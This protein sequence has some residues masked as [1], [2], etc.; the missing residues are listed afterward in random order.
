[1]LSFKKY[2]VSIVLSIVLLLGSFFAPAL[3]ISAKTVEKIGVGEVYHT[4]F[5]GGSE[6]GCFVFAPETNGFYTLNIIDYSQTS[7]VYIEIVDITTEQ[8]YKYIFE[9]V[10]ES[11]FV[12]EKMYMS[13]SHEYEVLCY[14]S[15]DDYYSDITAD[16]ALSFELSDFEPYK[17]PFC[18]ISSSRVMVSFE[19]SG[20]WFKFTTDV[21]GD[22]N[23]NY[24]VAIDAYVEV[25]N[26][27]SGEMV[28][29]RYTPFL[30]NYMGYNMWLCSE[31]LVFSLEANTEYYFYIEEYRNSTSKV[32]VTKS[33]KDIEN[34]A[35]SSLI[36]NVD[37]SSVDASD[38]S[39]GAFYFNIFYT[40]KTSQK[41]DYYNATSLGIEMPYVEYIGKTVYVNGLYLPISNTQPISVYYDGKYTVEYVNIPSVSD[42]LIELGYRSH[43]YF[44]TMEILYQNEDVYSE[45]KRIKVDKT[46]LYE[47][48][49]NADLNEAFSEYNIVLIDEQNNIVSSAGEYCWPL[50]AGREYVLCL[51][52]CYNEGFYNNL[53]FFISEKFENMY[54]DAYQN[55]WYYDAVTY[56]TGVNIMTGYQ[57]GRFGV[58]DNIQR[59]DF[60]VMLARFDGVDL[61]EYIDKQSPF[62][63][64]SNDPDCYF[65]AAVIWGYE[66]GIVSGYQDGNFG[67]G[68]KI[69]R[70]QLVTFLYRYANYKG[71]DT[72]YTTTEK[73]N[74]ENQ[75]SDFEFVTDFA[76]NSTIWAVTNGVI[77]GKTS[78]T[79]VPHGNALRCEV[80]QIMYNVFRNKVF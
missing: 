48:F 32:S 31:K 61:S 18:D 41:I 80:A 69:T 35:I 66:N 56:T 33:E 19:E 2:V 9:D 36:E 79:I 6:T 42:I 63:D 20:E 74:V 26:A 34:I 16:I 60:L 76:V 75:Y 52:Y 59:Q 47:L 45:Y 70:E 67:T 54:P 72:S 30:Y 24:S 68:D 50:V 29:S 77:N 12:S 8:P 4:T 62:D 37:W 51:D 13:G 11:G 39:A 22:Y 3:T 65:K 21:A 23:L 73:N 15:G 49:V 58:A 25:Y 38:I 40:D 17:L 57:D 7:D 1:M 27:K 44:D 78:T 10:N 43:S 28:S 5:K 14:Y 64:V 46:G 55:E 53:Y 71:L